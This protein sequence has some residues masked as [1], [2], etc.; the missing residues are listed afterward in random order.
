MTA[1]SLV[2]ARGSAA[3]RG[4][5]I[6]TRRLDRGAAVPAVDSA[7]RALTYFTEIQSQDWGRAFVHAAKRPKKF[8]QQMKAKMANRF[9][10]Y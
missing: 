6:A 3:C 4:G 7:E 10:W 5:T 9:S 1:V 2:R 8:G